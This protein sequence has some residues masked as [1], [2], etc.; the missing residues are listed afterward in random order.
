MIFE[1]VHEIRSSFENGVL[2][3]Y[4]ESEVPVE[5]TNDDIISVGKYSSLRPQYC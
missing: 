4:K 2:I 3:Q 5:L 1:I